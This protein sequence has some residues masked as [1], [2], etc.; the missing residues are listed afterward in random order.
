[1]PLHLPASLTTINTDCLDTIM[2]FLPEGSHLAPA[3]TCT[4]LA[5]Y[6]PEVSD[7]NDY[8]HSVDSL[9][10][11]ISC[12][13]ELDLSGITFH[14]A[15]YKGNV[16]VLSWLLEQGERVDINAPKLAVTLGHL[17]VLS[18]L[19]ATCRHLC[20]FDEFVCAAAARCGRLHILK[21]LRKR[22]VPWDSHVVM[23]AMDYWET[24]RDW[25]IL[26]WAMQ[27]GCRAGQGSASL[28][29][30]VGGLPALLHVMQYNMPID[31]YTM[32][33]AVRTEDEEMV[34]YL[35]DRGLAIMD[36]DDAVYITRYE[37]G[38]VSEEQED[39]EDEDEEPEDDEVD[40]E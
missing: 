21:W 23:G 11:A 14:K 26:N 10:F 24:T 34:D 31:E 37:Y 12:G 4:A 1:M 33:I 36:R 16:D 29:A 9:K 8:L 6:Q 30:R 18:W 7:I 17:H 13:Y 39:D 40:D 32:A 3:A 35:L 27:H 19:W 2:S 5:P 20:V 38:E 22:Y 25:T 15:L 28:A